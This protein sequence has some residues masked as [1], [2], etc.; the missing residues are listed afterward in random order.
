[1][2]ISD[3]K[4]VAHTLM[5]AATSRS[6]LE[7]TSEHCTAS[8]G[9]TASG[10]EIISINICGLKNDTQVTR[11]FRNQISPVS[12][13]C[14]F[15]IKMNAQDLVYRF[16]YISLTNNIFAVKWPK[17]IFSAIITPQ[18]YFLVFH[19]ICH[20]RKCRYRDQNQVSKT[21]ITKI[22]TFL[23]FFLRPRPV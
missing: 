20:P 12:F 9:K 21:N 13:K 3:R 7:V 15:A 1:M 23:I 14:G 11:I 18:G 19:G 2:K 16:S 4:T 17:Y 5:T 6:P 8:K 10:N 22:N